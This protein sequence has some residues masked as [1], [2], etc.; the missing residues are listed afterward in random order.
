MQRNLLLITEFI[1]I[2]FKSKIHIIN[3]QYEVSLKQIVSN[4]IENAFLPR[5]GPE[6]IMEFSTGGGGHLSLK[7]ITRRTTGARG[8]KFELFQS[9][10]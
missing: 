10:F 5:V 7:K 9:I 1:Q 2:N 3:K 6:K 4:I 8:N